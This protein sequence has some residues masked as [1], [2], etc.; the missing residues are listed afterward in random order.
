MAA[1]RLFLLYNSGSAADT[2]LIFG[3]GSGLQGQE[4]HFVTQKL[5]SLIKNQ[6][7]RFQ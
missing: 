1:A 4:I 3:L 5:V 6:P 2:A 7:L